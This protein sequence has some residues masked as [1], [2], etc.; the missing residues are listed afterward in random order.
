[1]LV[2]NNDEFAEKARLLRNHGMTRDATQFVGMGSSPLVQE[3]GPWYY[4]MNDLGFNYRITDLQCSHGISQLD[5][6]DGFIKRRAEIVES[7]NVAFSS[8]PSLKNP[9]RVSPAVENGTSWHLYTVQIDF[10]TIGKTRSEVMLELREL[11]VGTQVLYIP[12]Y[13][14]PY[15]QRTYGYEPG[16]CPTAESF[17]SR[18]LSLPLYPKMTD[19][20]V[21]HVIQSVERVI[22]SG[23]A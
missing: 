22:D 6:L 11:G 5:K 19:A 21:Q 13:L 9:T 23:E 4:E 3:R 2:T 10:G 7:Y 12:V 20:D 1:M 15:Y 14:Q 16:K 17:Y 8:N 18:A